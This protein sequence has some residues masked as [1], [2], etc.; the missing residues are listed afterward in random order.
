[1]Q[2]TSPNGRPRPP[3]DPIEEAWRHVVDN[4][5]DDEA[6]KQFFGACVA[7]DRLPEAGKR[8]RAVKNE[9]G[10]RAKKAE[11]QIGKLLALGMSLIQQDR[12]PPPKRTNRVVTSLVVLALALLGIAIVI[13]LSNP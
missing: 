2:S 1:M 4:W 3:T 7:A 5:N 9:G 13:G 8:Y 11:E 12:T 10:A 6:H